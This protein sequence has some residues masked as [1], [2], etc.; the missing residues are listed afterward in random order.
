[1]KSDKQLTYDVHEALRHEPAVNAT[2]VAVA[3]A[4]G[5]IT[6]T[7]SVPF[8]A[9]KHSAEAATLRVDG[10]KGLADELVVN[11]SGL[12]HFT[13]AE[14]AGAAVDAMRWHVWMPSH[15][16]VTVEDGWVTLSGSVTWDF[17]RNAARHSINFMHGVTGITNDITVTADTM[18][19]VTK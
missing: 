17:Q 16:Q 8:F 11:R 3:S 4:N 13:D 15:V 7:G 2:D 6:L 12:H 14:I 9:D 5:I 18:P 10:V 1:M 19:L